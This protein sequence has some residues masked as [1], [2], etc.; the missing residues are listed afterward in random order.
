MLAEDIDALAGRGDLAALLRSV[1]LCKLLHAA[2]NIQPEKGAQDLHAAVAVCLQKQAVGVL[3]DK[4]DGAECVAV[5]PEQADD[6]LLRKRHGRIARV[7]PSI[8]IRV[9]PLERKGSASAF[10][11]RSD[12]A[13]FLAAEGKGEGNGAALCA[14]AHPAADVFFSGLLIKAVGN[15]VHK[16]AALSDAILAVD[17]RHVYGVEVKGGF[18]IAT[19]VLY[20]DG[21]RREG[22]GMLSGVA[23]IVGLLD[24]GR[25]QFHKPGFI[26]LGDFCFV[27]PTGK[28]FDRAV[29]FVDGLLRAQLLDFFREDFGNVKS[30]GRKKRLLIFRTV[31]CF[32]LVAV[33][34]VAYSHDCVLDGL[35]LMI[36]LAAV[37]E[38]GNVL[39]ADVE[40]VVLSFGRG[41]K[42]RAPCLRR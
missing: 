25:G 41:N 14:I 37:N 23:A 18:R 15:R 30:A 17:H 40:C 27:Q 2:V 42:S 22:A 21:K 6:L 4:G 35:I 20:F 28:A 33:T 31:K 34:V 1:G 11:A 32:V 38:R 13:V 39:R 9:E 3:A 10:R 19:V 16:E 26:G 24:D 29:C 5:H 36:E 8:R 7:V 12:N